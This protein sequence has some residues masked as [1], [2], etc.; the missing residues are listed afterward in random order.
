MGRVS[1]LH[2]TVIAFSTAESIVAS[3]EPFP[4][5]SIY[6]ELA[7]SVSEGESRLDYAKGE[8]PVTQKHSDIKGGFRAYQVYRKTANNHSGKSDI[9]CASSR[10]RV[11]SIEV[12]Y[13]LQRTGPYAYGHEGPKQQP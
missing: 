2:W 5:V 6:S 12:V 4:S 10:S 13:R 9:R 1:H 3:S 8:K 11:Q 7:Q